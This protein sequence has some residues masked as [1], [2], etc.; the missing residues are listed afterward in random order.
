[1]YKHGFQ[2]EKTI[3]SNIWEYLLD[4]FNNHNTS[5]FIQSPSILLTQLIT[6]SRNL[7]IQ[8]PTNETNMSLISFYLAY[9]TE[10]SLEQDSPLTGY[11]QYI[12]FTS[13]YMD[14]YKLY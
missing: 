8:C 1:M 11:L 13:W 3:A 12:L 5:S 4:L 7:S 2:K 6:L 10:Q 14:S 9:L